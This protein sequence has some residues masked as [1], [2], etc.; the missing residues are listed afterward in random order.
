MK[1]ILKAIGIGVALGL[2]LL[3]VKQALNIPEE[4]FM[5]TYWIFG[6]AVVIAAVLFNHFY[7]RSYL[8]KMKTAALLLEQGKPQEYIKAVETLRQK[9]K[10]RYLQNLFILNLSAGYCDLKEYKKAIELLKS[11]ENARLYQNLKLVYHIN[12]CVCYFYDGQTEKAMTL[13]KSSQKLFCTSLATKLYGGNIAVLDVFALVEQRE[14]DR[15][16]EVLTTA[17]EAWSDSRLQADF[18]Y[19]EEKLQ[20]EQK[21]DLQ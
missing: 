12:L 21:K 14:Y 19:L 11:L 8:K 5:K 3:F 13:Y 17:R 1:H 10:G 18:E 20:H 16:K 2:L 4:I 15:A 7:H 9:A 6:A